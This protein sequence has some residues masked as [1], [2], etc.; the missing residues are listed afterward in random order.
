LEPALNSVDFSD[1]SRPGEAC[2]VFGVYAPETDAAHLI[3][4]GL[5]ALQHRGQ[6]SAG[7]GVSDGETVTVS[8]DLGLVSQI[9]DEKSLAGLPGHLGIGH[10]RYSTT[11][12][13]TWDNAQPAFRQVGTTGI[14]LGHN[15]NLTNTVELGERLGRQAGS[16]DSELMLEAIALEVQDERADG[17]QLERAMMQ[18]LPEFEG[19]FSLVAMDQGHV[20]GVRDPRGF[21]PLSIGR[22]ER[23][24]WVLASETAALDLV[25]AGFVREVEPGEMVVINASGLRSFRPFA[26]AEPR[27]CVFEF[28]YFARPD[29]RL[30]GQNIHAARQ[31]MG[32]LL[33]AESPVEADVVVP[34]PESG[35]PAAQGFSNA[36]GIPYAD[37]LVKN[38]YVGRTFIEPSQMLRDRGIRLKLNP[39]PA[40]LENKRVVLVDDS[41]VRGTTTRQLVAMVREA[42][43]KEIHVRVSSPPYRWPCFYGM[44]TADRS[45]LLAAHQT[46]EEIGAYLACDSLAYLTLDSLLAATGAGGDGFCTACLSGEYPTPVPTHGHKLALE[47][48]S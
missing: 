46:L 14:A 5:F 35:I 15:G 10:T 37:G 3:S 2:G 38:R 23:G 12:S 30:N 19:A 26:P 11:G 13:T 17:R 25:G 16:S 41:I 40:T 27:L 6:E 4:F 43:A 18:A 33:A 45:K 24:G 47:G 1:H 28:V 36:S 42:G 39:I 7:I 44:D 9:F 31:A 29:S 20:V 48:G 32:R 21:R 34:V 8:K 22:L